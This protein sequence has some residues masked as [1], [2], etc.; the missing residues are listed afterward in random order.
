MAKFMWGAD[1]QRSSGSYIVPITEAKIWEK[2]FNNLTW[3]L[4]G[5][6]VAVCAQ[7]F[8]HRFEW[9]EA[10]ALNPFEYLVKRLVP[11]FM[12]ALAE[13]HSIT[14]KDGVR[15]SGGEYLICVSASIYR[16]DSHGNVGH[17][18]R[19]FTAIGSGREFATGSLGT[20]AAIGNILPKARLKFALEE[21]A[22]GNT[23]VNNKF[24]FLSA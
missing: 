14:I 2:K 22:Q 12:K 6:G 3:I 20:T 7:I 9:P 23:G 24:H 15:N 8:Q 5:S 4:G 1:T 11:A 17:I 10:G 13:S 21:A 16:I 18:E 19:N